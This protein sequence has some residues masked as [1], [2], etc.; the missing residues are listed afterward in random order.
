MSDNIFKND[1]SNNN[2]V[3]IEFGINEYSHLFLALYVIKKFSSKDTPL[4][5]YDLKSYMNDIINI[6]IDKGILFSNKTIDYDNNNYK[7]IRQNLI[8]VCN[9]YSFANQIFGG[10]FVH[11]QK[12]NSTKPHHYFYFEPVATESDIYMINGAI[13]SNK[14]LSTEEKNYLI[15]VENYLCPYAGEKVREYNKKNN[16][17][18]KNLKDPYIIENLC[19]SFPESPVKK[20]DNKKKDNRLP[21]D[22]KTQLFNISRI[23]KAINEKTMLKLVYGNYDVKNNRLSFSS[24]SPKRVNPYSLLWNNGYYYLV[25]T[26]ENSDSP[27]NLRV[28]RIISVEH[29]ENEDDHRIHQSRQPAP[30]ALKPFYNEYGIFQNNKYATTYPRMISNYDTDEKTTIILECTATTLSLIIDTFGANI[31]VREST[32]PHEPAPTD[33]SGK[34]IKFI[35]VMIHNVQYK[36]ALLFCLER[37]SSLFYTYPTISALYPP[38]LVKAVKESITDDNNYY[39]ELLNKL[40]EIRNPFTD[41]NNF[42]N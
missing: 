2:P 11:L 41:N 36:N 21:L 5:A 24:H 42:S 22:S 17:N 35:I 38:K 31:S 34:P 15:A 40:P 7:S 12:G 19:T 29:I 3:P 28:D 10:R 32:I 30:P 20:A 6:Y 13:E 8:K 16:R 1:N 14:Y 33:Y 18:E 23:H 37:A 4:N 9:D 25:C 39:E 26:Y 27:R